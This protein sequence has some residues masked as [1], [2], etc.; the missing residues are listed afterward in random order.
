MYV[1]LRKGPLPLRRP[2]QGFGDRSIDLLDPT[3]V[4]LCDGKLTAACV[5]L[6]TAVVALP[7]TQGAPFA[8]PVDRQRFPDGV[9]GAQIAARGGGGQ[10]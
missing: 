8:S 9:H 7:C 1:K 3:M 4:G 5:G 10:I 2:H 6:I